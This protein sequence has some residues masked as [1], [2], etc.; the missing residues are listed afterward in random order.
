MRKYKLTRYYPQK[1]EI[2]VL[3]IQII[4]MFP[5][6]IQEHPTFGTIKRVWI[7]EK[8]IYH[9][10]KYSDE[11][12]EKLSSTKLYTKLKDDVMRKILEGLSEFKIILYYQDKEDV[13]QVKRV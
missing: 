3:D 4:S 12:T 11:Y 13:Y 1:I 2:E 8:D 5:I 10:E 6:E 9:V 7:T